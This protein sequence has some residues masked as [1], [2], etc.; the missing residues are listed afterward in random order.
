MNSITVDDVN[1]GT[2]FVRNKTE[3]SL[4]QLKTLEV[5]LWKHL[6]LDQQFGVLCDEISVNL[7]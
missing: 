7:E 2:S 5:R 6:V 3:R 4:S 1:I